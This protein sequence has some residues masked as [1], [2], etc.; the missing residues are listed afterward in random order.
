MLF[1]LHYAF[2]YFPGTVPK[3]EECPEVIRGVVSA[4]SG[5]SP[6]DL[7]LDG[8]THTL[9]LPVGVYNY[10]IKGRNTNCSLKVEI[11]GAGYSIIYFML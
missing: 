5:L 8:T 7:T 1:N 6:L 4:S 9:E 11:K 2:N 3:N 10:R